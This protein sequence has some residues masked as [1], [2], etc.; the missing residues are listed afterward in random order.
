[1]KSYNLTT[2]QFTYVQPFN[3]MLNGKVHSLSL[4]YPYSDSVICVRVSINTNNSIR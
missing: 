2:Q 4:L 3:S 1:M